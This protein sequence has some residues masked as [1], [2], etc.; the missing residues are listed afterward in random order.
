MIVLM[1]DYYTKEGQ[2]DAVAATL[3]EM[4]AYCNS[5][6]E[7]GCAMYI[8]NRAVDDPRH[9]LLYEQYVDQAAL[10][11]HTQTAMFQEKIL[12]TA[13]PMLESRRRSFWTIVE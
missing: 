2:D 9:F 12:G 13:V 10:E 5:D 1:A 6:A 8:V 7:P 3:R 11:A 4:A